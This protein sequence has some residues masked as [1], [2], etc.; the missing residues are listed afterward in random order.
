MII[1]KIGEKYL[2]IIGIIAEFFSLTTTQVS[3]IAVFKLYL[4]LVFGQT[5]LS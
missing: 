4:P 5:V 2:R 3:Y 1:L